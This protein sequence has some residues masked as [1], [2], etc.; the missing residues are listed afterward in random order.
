[1]RG[2]DGTHKTQMVRWQRLDRRE[3]KTKQL[4]QMR[5]KHGTNWTEERARKYGLDR[6]EGKTVKIEQMRGLEGTD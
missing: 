6:W 1:M 4:G 2:K 5:G 3:G